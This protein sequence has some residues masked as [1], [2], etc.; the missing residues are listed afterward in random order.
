MDTDSCL[1]FRPN[2][3]IEEEQQQQWNLEGASWYGGKLILHKPSSVD[4]TISRF[5]KL[6]N[7]S[8]I[9]F[10]NTLYRVF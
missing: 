3:N 7:F 8:L 4:I 2:P 1:D 10:Q 9:D 6:M 5:Q